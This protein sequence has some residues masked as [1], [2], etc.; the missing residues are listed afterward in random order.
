LIISADPAHAILEIAGL[1]KLGD[2]GW[3]LALIDND[4]YLFRTK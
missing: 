4:P 3:E 2:E 1:N